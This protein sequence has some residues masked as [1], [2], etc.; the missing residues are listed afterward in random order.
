MKLLN[1]NEFIDY[2]QLGLRYRLFKC[3][4]LFNRSVCHKLRGDEK[5]SASDLCVAQRSCCTQDHQ[6][7]ILPAAKAG[8]SDLTL[9]TVPYDVI[10]EVSESKLKNIDKR[11]LIPDAKFVLSKSDDNSFAGFSGASFLPQR[12]GELDGLCRSAT[13]LR[14][15][16]TKRNNAEL[17]RK[18][19]KAS[20]IASDDKT[21]ADTNTITN[22]E[23][24]FADYSNDVTYRSPKDSGRTFNS[25]DS[26]PNRTDKTN[27]W[28]KQ[29]VL[30]VQLQSN[31]LMKSFAS[32]SNDSSSADNSVSCDQ[33]FMLSNSLSSFS[34]SKAD[35]VRVKVHF[36]NNKIMA[37]VV[38]L[39]IDLESFA[40]LVQKKQKLPCLPELVYQDYDSLAGAANPTN[41]ISIIDDED[42]V[43]ALNL[44]KENKTRMYSNAVL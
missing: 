12:Q 28:S 35:L 14:R 41:L 34:G 25:P 37:L 5:Q 27:G 38:P 18:P 39:D 17:D 10:F 11:C 33:S 2:T 40:S 42:L 15:N 24:P 44:V 21:V 22:S 23:A 7:I 26:S 8:L 19:S 30:N 13:I 9:F 36:D 16:T 32:N 29:P 1:E 4:V 6:N 20:V 31:D 3:E 43:Y